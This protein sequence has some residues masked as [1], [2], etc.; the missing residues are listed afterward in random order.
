MKLWA[1][2]NR[3]ENTHDAD[4]NRQQRQFKPLRRDF[5]GDAVRLPLYRNP[6]YDQLSQPSRATKLSVECRCANAQDNTTIAL[7]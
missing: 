6:V 1:V 5:D 2:F 3:L 4:K 7:V